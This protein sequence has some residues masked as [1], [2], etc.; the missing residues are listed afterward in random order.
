MFEVGDLVRV[1]DDAY[2]ITGRGI[3]FVTDMQEFCGK[4]FVVFKKEISN[5]GR[6]KYKLDGVTS[7]NAAMNGDGYWVFVEEWLEPANNK[8]IS[9]EENEIEMMFN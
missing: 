2:E 4:E 5:T 7:W 3:N 9:I 6:V 1:K 8:K